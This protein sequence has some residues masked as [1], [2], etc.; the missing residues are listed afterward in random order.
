[1][2]RVGQRN[3]LFSEIEDAD[4]HQLGNG[5]VLEA[6]ALHAVN[7]IGSD[8]EDANLDELIEGGLESK[9]TD[10]AHL[11]GVSRPAP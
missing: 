3:A 1:M 8:L 6:A 9:G 10:L 11:V 7:E 5:E 4:L 2:C